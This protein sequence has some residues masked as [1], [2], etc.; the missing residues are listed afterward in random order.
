M[1]AAR[2]ATWRP[3]GFSSTAVQMLRLALAMGRH[4]LRP[5]FCF[6][7]VREAP[8]QDRPQK[9]CEHGSGM[10]KL[11]QV[12]GPAG[13]SSGCVG[14]KNRKILNQSRFCRVHVRNILS[15]R[16]PGET[17]EQNN[18]TPWLILMQWLLFG[19][20]RMP[21]C[22]SSAF[23]AIFG[24][25]SYESVQGERGDSLPPKS[26][27]SPGTWAGMRWYQVALATAHVPIW[28]GRAGGPA[29]KP[30]SPTRQKHV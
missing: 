2:Q 17:H 24:L 13:N 30:P 28:G 16:A 22:N 1:R 11:Y 7:F 3:S 29:G 8:M 6:F 9:K 19:V 10:R 5:G 15:T 23:K 4:L 25:Q 26:L 18:R 12:D 27:N 21:K 14:H 20:E